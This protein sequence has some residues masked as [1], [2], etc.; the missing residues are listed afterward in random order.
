MYSFRRIQRTIRNKK[1]NLILKT[2]NQ[3]KRKPARYDLWGDA[4]KE[5]RQGSLICHCVSKTFK[6]FDPINFNPYLNVP[7]VI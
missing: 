4:E 2:Y 1:R 3:Q 5:E 7:E 6:S